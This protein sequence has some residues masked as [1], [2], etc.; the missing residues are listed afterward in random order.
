[1]TTHLKGQKMYLAGEWVNS[2]KVIEVRDPQDNRII[3]TVPA[4]AAEDMLKCV[5]EAKEG[6]KIAAAMPVH[7]RM[8]VINAAAD[9]IEKNSER[10]ARTLASE[11][12]KTIREAGKEVGRAIQTLRISAEEARRINGETIS[13]DQSPGSENRVG[14]FY[15]FPIG[16]I[17]A[18]TPFNDP[19]NLVAHKVG[20]AI[21]SG[22]AIIVKPAT[23]TPLSALLLA[24]AFAHAEL[25]MKVLSVIT[26]HGSEIGDALVTHPAVRM[27]SFTGGVEAAEEIARK[28]G[29]KKL[30]MELGSNSP[31]IVLSDADLEDAIESSVSGAFWAAGQNCLGVQR[32]YIQEGVFEAF[33]EKFVGRATD[34][35][36]GDKQSELTDMGP[37][38][39][40][41]EAIRVEKLVNEAVKKGAKILTGGERDGAFYSPTVLIDVPENCTIAREEIFGPVVL[42]YPVADLEEAIHLSNNVNYGLQAGIFTKNIDLA[43][44]AI[45]KLDVGGIMVNDS[46]DFRIDA[47]P[48]G[49]VK[50]SGLGREGI[51]FSIQ[52]M[53]EPKVVCFKL[54]N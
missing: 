45:A 11:S 21:A 24:E 3:D 16:I 47:M 38:I 4:A 1:M 51:K 17:G 36:V 48:F 10:Y 30:G 44:K 31:V 9:Y 54:S 7:Q 28:A 15:R 27:I 2:E 5:E 22:N 52:E 46:S 19:L 14:Y 41:K 43:H 12:S 39:T 37:L 25:P 23:V 53:T 20:P 33:K 35:L 42:L 6:A 49:G 40:E 29:L 34:Y 18:I 13:F 26:G 8:A 32:I 50:Q